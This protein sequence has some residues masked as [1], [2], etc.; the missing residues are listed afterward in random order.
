[1]EAPTLHRALTY[2]VVL[3]RRIVR[4]DQLVLALLAMV[5]GMGVGVGVIGFRSLLAGVQ[6]VFLGFTSEL[7][8]T[9]ASEL[10]WW[11]ILLAPTIGG[12][13]VGIL[14]QYV[15]PG[16]RPQ[17][18][19]HVMEA[20]A[21]RSGRMSLR[22]GLA[23]A[24]VSATSL[25][26]GASTG[27]EGPAVHLG[28]TIGSLV[29]QWLRV[30]TGLSRTLLGCGVSAAVATSFNAPIAGVF[31]AVEVVI[32]HYA[33]RA[34]APVVIAAVSATI[35]TRLHYGD[36]PAFVLQDTIGFVSFLEFPAFVMLGVVCA[37]VA[38]AEMWS[39]MGAEKL[40]NRLNPPWLIRPAI[41]GLVVG[42]MAIE[43]PHLLGVGYETTDMALKELLPLHLL[44][45][46]L[47]AKIAATAISLGFG[48]GGGVFS[49]SLFIGA[50]AGGAFGTIATSIFPEYSSGVD[51]YTLIG[52]GAVSACIL[53]APISTI[54]IVFELT[55]DYTLTIAVMASVVIATIITE[56][57]LG[58][59]L[60]TWQ[61]ERRGIN[62]KAGREVDLMAGTRISDLMKSDHSVVDASAGVDEVADRLKVARYGELFV[63]KDGNRLAGV[64]MLP[65]LVPALSGDKADAKERADLK[66]ID[67][68]RHD[69]PILVADDDIRRA[70]E[71]MDHAGESHIAV[72]T[73]TKSRS[74]VGF[75]HE[76]DVMLAY[77]RAV[78]QARAEERGETTALPSRW[79]RRRRD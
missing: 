56:Q 20:S 16:G 79:W 11:H 60:F 73:D 42:L 34:F 35:V 61:L 38:L 77:H 36:F 53:G 2:L 67:I 47:A 63:V 4:N 6:F 1:M 28:A 43:F 55:G 54:L 27:R 29:A 19:P 8:L 72:V 75:V 22:T 31:F 21:L 71:I 37:I 14:L 39:I 30:S 23:A 66:A 3:V 57:V 26:V 24:L 58:N 49:P 69:P 65:D 44:L 9:Y 45:I 76:H 18:V 52:M 15:M 41:G 64:I 70:M 46:L 50:M 12:L 74:L 10:P 59:S 7:V 13:L 17:G 78:L 40:A 33:L 25:G 32:G 68:A 62:L 48:F 51:A 5:I